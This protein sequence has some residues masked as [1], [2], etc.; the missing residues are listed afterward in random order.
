MVMI[1]KQ[2]VTAE[3]LMEMPEVPGKGFEL[4]DGEVVE[5]VRLPMPGMG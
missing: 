3:E 1:V 2:R 5:D 4:V